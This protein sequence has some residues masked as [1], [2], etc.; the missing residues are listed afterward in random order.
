MLLGECVYGSGFCCS[1]HHVSNESSGVE[2]V[3]GFGVGCEGACCS[4]SACD[5]R[6]H[7]GG[8]CGDEPDLVSGCD[9][10]VEEFFGAWVDPVGEDLV[11]Y[12]FTYGDYFRYGVPFHEVEGAGADLVDVVFV[13]AEHDVSEL[14]DAECDDVAGAE[15]SAPVERFG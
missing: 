10:L 1:V 3:F 5:E 4:E 14:F 13:F 9:V 2:P 7:F 6:A 12:L 11:V 15:E 8:C